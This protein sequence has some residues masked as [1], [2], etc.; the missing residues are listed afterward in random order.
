Y[1]DQKKDLTL[2][3]FELK[4]K[5]DVSAHEA[6]LKKILAKIK[7]VDAFL[8]K[9]DTSFNEMSSK[10]P[11]QSFL[12]LDKYRVTKD[13][14]LYPELKNIYDE[15]FKKDWKQISGIRLSDDLKTVIKIE[16]GKETSKEKFN[17]S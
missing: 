9:K 10:K 7:E 11:H 17:M 8:Q 14:D 13:S 4:K 2:G 5:Q 15:L 1:F 6:R 3:H 16:D 12:L